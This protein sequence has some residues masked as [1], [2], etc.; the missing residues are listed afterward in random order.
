MFI[1]FVASA[2]LISSNPTNLVLSGAF[3]LSFITYTSSVVLPFLAA[4]LIVYLYLAY[5][6]FRSAESI[7]PSI[8]VSHDDASVGGDG[9]G[10]DRPSAALVD[11]TGAIFGSILLM[12]TLGALVGTSTAGIPVWRVT[13]P[14]ATMM[15]SRDLWWDWR[16]H[17][18]HRA[19][20]KE[21]G[22]EQLETHP[23]S[24]VYPPTE[25]QNLPL[26]ASHLNS[27][28]P[29]D[30]SR[31]QL[32][33]STIS[34][35][36]TQRFVETFPAIHAVCRQLPLTLVP[37]SFLMFILVQGL[38]SQGW[39][40]LFGNW[41]DAWVNKTGVVGAVGGMLIGSG[42]LCNV[43]HSF[44][45][46]L[47]ID[48]CNHHVTTDMWH[49]YRHDHFSGADVTRVGVF[50]AGHHPTCAI[51]VRVQPCARIE[52]RGIHAHVFGIAGRPVMAGHSSTEGYPSWAISVRTVERRH[53]RSSGREFGSSADRTDVGRALIDW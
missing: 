32:A 23:P 2:V 12:A 38:T 18:T 36:W 30:N 33:L 8:E 39:V 19:V 3:S 40:R 28:N 47:A 46:P 45:P 1:N 22:V 29:G 16:R 17:R 43:C 31:R 14:A 50:R 9:V 7:P 49:E 53:V 42:L 35:T 25:L 52:L 11:K 41:W 34:S 51:R 10:I 44:F 15:L 13:V 27:H 37:F 6:L 20:A 48:A 26:S 21:P 4:A 24:A 5:V